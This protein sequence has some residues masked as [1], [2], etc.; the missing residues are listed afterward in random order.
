MPAW[1]YATLKT[2][3]AALNPLPPDIPS[4]VAAI[5]AQTITLTNQPFA[6][7]AA[8][9]AARTAGTGDW[10]RVI[11]RSRQTPA[12]P[13]ATAN[14]AACLAAINAVQLSDNDIIDPTNAAEWATFQAG[15]T[16]LAATGDLAAATIVAINALTTTTLPA[17]VPAVTAGDVQTAEAQP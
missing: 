3:L 9:L 16:A 10:S 15:L 5:N 2:A 6:W 14:D 12:L 11:A 1:T 4:Q 7:M 8:R 17:W 13:P